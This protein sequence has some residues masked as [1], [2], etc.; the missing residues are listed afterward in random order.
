MTRQSLTDQDFNTPSKP[1]ANKPKPTGIADPT[2]SEMPDLPGQFDGA[3]ELPIPSKRPPIPTRPSLGARARSSFRGHAKS[4]SL[5]R[6]PT[7]P[8]LDQDVDPLS[9]NNPLRPIESPMTKTEEEML[10]IQTFYQRIVDAE[11]V[12]PK[13]IP[14][15]VFRHGKECVDEALK[16]IKR[17]NGTH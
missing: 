1:Q 6:P 15:R 8:L 2:F 9:P 12:L 10:I 13:K 17:E 5:S 11:R 4:N 14:L 7:P 3:H 16:I